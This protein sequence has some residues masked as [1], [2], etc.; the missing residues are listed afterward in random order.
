MISISINI[1]R[2]GAR[3]H[4]NW[5][6]CFERRISFKNCQIG[7]VLRNILT[8]FE[9]PTKPTRTV[10]LYFL[11]FVVA[12][13]VVVRENFVSEASRQSQKKEHSNKSCQQYNEE[14][15]GRTCWNLTCFMSRRHN[16]CTR[17]V[18]LDNLRS[19]TSRAKHEDH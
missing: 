17:Q 2:L 7:S 15:E 19:T 13:K 5:I 16:N 18:D 14:R 8:K 12:K 1:A 4:H 6:G 3:G 9:S 10:G 11:N